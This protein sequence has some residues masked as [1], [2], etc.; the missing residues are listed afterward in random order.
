MTSHSFCLHW[1]YSTMNASIQ[2]NSISLISA[3]TVIIQKG[4]LKDTD[5]NLLYQQLS[6]PFREK[7]GYSFLSL[8]GIS[9]ESLMVPMSPL[10]VSTPARQHASPQPLVLSNHWTAPIM[11]LV[12]TWVQFVVSGNH[13]FIWYPSIP[14]EIR[15]PWRITSG[16]LHPHRISEFLMYVWVV[17]SFTSLFFIIWVIN[18]PYLISPVW[19]AKGDFYFPG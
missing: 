18:S 14:R 6:F 8:F 3:H 15:A 7:L 10:H 16:L 9:K 17:P 19:K 5:K 12:L 11:V 13:T 4:S 1:S 2:H